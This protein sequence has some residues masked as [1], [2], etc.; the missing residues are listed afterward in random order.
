MQKLLASDEGLQEAYA[1]ADSFWKLNNV[2]K[3]IV[4]DK[5]KEGKAVCDVTLLIIVIKCY[6]RLADKKEA[7]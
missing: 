1:S 2:L 6:D 3:L 4:S 7:F 5:N